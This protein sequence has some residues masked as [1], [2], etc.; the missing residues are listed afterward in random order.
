M[1]R[2]L[3]NVGDEIVVFVLSS[4]KGEQPSVSHKKAIK[5]ANIEAKNQR[6]GQ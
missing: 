1:G 2:S 5:L 4:G 3:F 6:A